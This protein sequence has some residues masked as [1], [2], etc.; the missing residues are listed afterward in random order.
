MRTGGLGVLLVRSLFAVALISALAWASLLLWASATNGTL[1]Y[2]YEAYRRAAVRL[3]GHERLYDVSA[4]SFGP[5][6]LYFYPPPFAFFAIPFALLGDLGRWV[7]TGGL[8]AASAAAVALAPVSRRTRLLLVLLAALSWP[9][10]YAIKLGQVGPVL[11][12]LFVIGWRWIDRPLP[13]GL[14]IGLGTIIK[15]QPALLIGWA[16][17]TGRR[18]AAAI[19]LLLLVALGAAFTLFAGTQPWFDWL[20]VLG[21]VTR[22]AIADYDTGF[23]RQAVIAGASLEL[24]TAVHYLNA[25]AVA[26]V[27]LLTVFRGSPIAGY[28]AVVVATQFVSPVLWSHYALILLLPVAW[29]LDRGWVWTVVIPLVTSTALTQITPAIAYPVSFWVTLVAVAWMGLRD[30]RRTSAVPAAEAVARAAPAAT[31][32]GAEAG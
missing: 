4:T 17:V 7:W 30:A 14:S 21:R 19:G 31:A 28:M 24:G 20:A 13:L 10:N 29:L 9:L 15:I 26:A 25:A 1:G 12:L 22:P 6:A 8:I 5:A 23:G 11:L 16:V 18:R 32:M 27:T 2:D 3:L